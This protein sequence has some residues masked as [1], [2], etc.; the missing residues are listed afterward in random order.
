MS[1][2]INVSSL[3][4]PHA[5]IL[6]PDNPP[7]KDYGVDLLC[8]L[9]GRLNYMVGMFASKEDEKIADKITIELLKATLE[10]IRSV[11]KRLHRFP[12][13]VQSGIIKELARRFS[14]LL[15]YVVVFKG[16]EDI[17]KIGP[18]IR[19]LVDMLILHRESRQKNSV[20]HCKSLAMSIMETIEP[21]TNCFRR[22]VMLENCVILLD[23]YLSHE[24]LAMVWWMATGVPG[25]FGTVNVEL[26]TEKL[27]KSMVK[28]IEAMDYSSFYYLI[29][30]H[31]A[32][33]ADPIRIKCLPVEVLNKVYRVVKNFS[34]IDGRFLEKFD[35]NLSEFVEHDCSSVDLLIGNRKLFMVVMKLI[36]EG[37][38]PESTMEKLAPAIVYFLSGNVTVTSSDFTYENKQDY[39]AVLKDFRNRKEEILKKIPAAAL[40]EVL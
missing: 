2:I 21:L 38:F 12:L 37:I 16:R 14:V 20:E 10:E 31:A 7:V 27:V 22:K 39:I 3:F 35:R 6:S 11:K 8:K 19:D 36:A 34:A 18:I 26:N 13:E 23:H 28:Y 40:S 1:K 5:N 15:A 29:A 33:N 4:T 30:K 17:E 25:Y 24:V 32:E 9:H